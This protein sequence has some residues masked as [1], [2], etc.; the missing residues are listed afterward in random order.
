MKNLNKQPFVI[1][2]D[3]TTHIR[4]SYQLNNKAV[5]IEQGH[6]VVMLSIEDIPSFIKA[7]SDVAL[8]ADTHKV[9]Q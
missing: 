6:D 9:E 2:F 1:E 7:L 4:A 5:F 3:N 8:Y